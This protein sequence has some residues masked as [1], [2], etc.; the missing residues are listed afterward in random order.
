MS[1]DF[2]GPSGFLSHQS[3]CANKLC[4]FRG[5]GPVGD[6]EGQQSYFLIAEVDY[7][8]RILITFYTCIIQ[9]Q[10]PGQVIFPLHSFLLLKCASSPPEGHMQSCFIAV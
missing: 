10:T 8:N 9:L 6:S 4:V 5:L 7:I 3:N 1:A 2:V